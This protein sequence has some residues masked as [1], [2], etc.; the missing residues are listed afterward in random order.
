[1][2]LDSRFLPN[3]HWVAELRPL[4]GTDAAVKQYVLGRAETRVFLDQVVM[5]VR[6]LAPLFVAE[7]K[8]RLVM[9]VGCTGG[10]HRSVVLVDDLAERLREDAAVVTTVSYRD[11]DREV[12]R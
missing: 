6:F 12:L 2:V 4:T 11:I 3:P 10:R 8:R 7:Q 5:L 1:M 9:A